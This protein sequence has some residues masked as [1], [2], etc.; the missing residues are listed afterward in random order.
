MSWHDEERSRRSVMLPQLRGLRWGPR[1]VAPE[2]ALLLDWHISA[3]P[4][5]VEAPTMF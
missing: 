2:E 1:E 3:C 5:A 4:D